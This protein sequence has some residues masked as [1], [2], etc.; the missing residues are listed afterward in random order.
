[1]EKRNKMYGHEK[2]SL[3]KKFDELRKTKGHKKTIQRA[4]RSA[5]DRIQ[6]VNRRNRCHLGNAA[7]ANN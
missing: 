2:K 4:R 1:M 7:L 5:I 6:G 3:K